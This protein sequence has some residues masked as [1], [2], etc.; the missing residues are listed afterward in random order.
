[1]VPP[2]SH[3][4]LIPWWEAPIIS[5]VQGTLLMDYAFSRQRSFFKNAF[6][7]SNLDFRRRDG[8]LQ[9]PTVSIS[10]Q[11]V[12]H[13]QGQFPDTG[14]LWCELSKGLLIPSFGAQEVLGTGTPEI[15]RK[16][17]GCARVSPPSSKQDP[18]PW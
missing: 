1:M 15:D 17:R 12:D 3:S 2:N 8:I 7:D 6:N 13:T 9:A 4:S 11:R 14:P 18:N 5:L 16:R 10:R